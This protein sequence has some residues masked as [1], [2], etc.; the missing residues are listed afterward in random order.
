M[1]ISSISRNKYVDICTFLEPVEA[2]YTNLESFTQLHNPNITWPVS[3]QHQVP[4][5]YLIVVMWQPDSQYL[6]VWQPDLIVKSDQ[7]LTIHD[8]C[9][10]I[11]RLQF[12]RPKSYAKKRVFHDIC[13]YPTIVRKWFEMGLNQSPCFFT[14]N[15]LFQHLYTYSIM[16]YAE[17]A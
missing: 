16:N 14:L 11:L 1:N 3:L 17:S 5:S 4:F 15:C 2:F 13:F 9:Q 10:K 12:L 7:M 8:S 6:I